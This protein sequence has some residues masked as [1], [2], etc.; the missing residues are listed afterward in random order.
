MQP[1]V[2]QALSLA[3][4]SRWLLFCLCTCD[5]DT[6]LTLLTMITEFISFFLLLFTCR[7]LISFLQHTIGLVSL[8]PCL[9]WGSRLQFMFRCL[10]FLH[11]HAPTPA[12][13]TLQ[14]SLKW[15]NF[16]NSGSSPW[17][18]S[19]VHIVCDYCSVTPDA[20]P[21]LCYPSVGLRRM[22][23]IFHS[24]DSLGSL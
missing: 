24:S 3:V 4:T 18:I 1:W 14:T 2:I 9:P 17:N 16:L 8:H 22:Q 10:R 21:A 7:S 20:D 13:I 23:E 15:I 11:F 19:R 6:W 12:L 5:L